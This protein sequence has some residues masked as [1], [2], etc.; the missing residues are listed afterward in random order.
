M[1]QYLP[2]K[3]LGS[4]LAMILK[5]NGAV[6]T[7]YWDDAATTNQYIEIR[8]KRS[9]AAAFL[10]SLLLHVLV[11][12]LLHPKQSL[13]TSVIANPRLKSISV[14]I[15]DLPTKPSPTMPS[16]ASQANKPELKPQQKSTLP[17]VISVDKPA[18]ITA[19][20]IIPQSKSDATDLMS[21]IK[22]KKQQEQALEDDAI[23]NN[24]AAVARERKPSADEFR[25]AIIKRN[26]Q[27]EGT[28][29]IFEI[30]SK[31]DRTAKFS[32][33][34]WKND[35]SNSRLEIIDVEAGTN[36]DIDLAIVRSMIEV[37]RRDYK[38]DFN[39]ESQRL[40]RVIV[41]SARMQD[42]AGLEEFLMREFFTN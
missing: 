22:T 34:G 11:L 21:Y 14:R 3:H 27:Q 36:N 42:N 6:Q 31:N 7:A 37:I 38:G 16:I 19:P 26:M 20:L 25:N 32:F 28:N 8:I 15:A 23:Q 1:S 5:P 10:L 40:G 2:D 41:L 9:T 12:F 30:R 13:E 24:A 39:W 4:Y 33:K 17:S 29:G 18:V 35:S